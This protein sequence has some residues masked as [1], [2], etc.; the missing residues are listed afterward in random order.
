[1]R[2]TVGAVRG[3][4]RPVLLLVLSGSVI[5]CT[6]SNPAFQGVTQGGADREEVGEAAPAS[7]DALAV[8]ARSMPDAAADLDQP[9]QDAARPDAPAGV[10]DLAAGP[11][12][13]A[14][15]LADVAATVPDTRPA[16]APGADGPAPLFHYD[17]ES[18]TQG[19]KDI[20]YMHY[21][22]RETPVTTSSAVAHRGARS[23]A[24]TIM[25]TDEKILPSFGVDARPIKDRL[26][27]G[28]RIEHWVWFPAGARLL[29]VQ[30]FVYCYRLGEA[31]PR[32]EGNLTPIG[33]L[34]PGR[35]NRIEHQVPANVDVPAGGVVD[36]GIEWN[37]EGALTQPLTVY[38]DDV[39]VWAP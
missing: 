9:R 32:W 28:T 30:G 27:A 3:S 24:M 26:I 15:D 21:G 18:G 35:W 11:P 25:T 2:A 7:P 13:V 23:L 1:M 34:M 14:A 19:W 16:D 39:S 22:V 6:R 31:E 38:I 36:F 12:D 10:P 17:F 33:D 8:D 4:I 5:S 20:R 37:G 29:G